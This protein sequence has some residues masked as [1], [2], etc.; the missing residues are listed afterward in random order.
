MTENKS[1]FHSAVNFCKSFGGDWISW[2]PNSSIAWFS[3]EEYLNHMNF[4][5]P[6]EDVF[7]H[8]ISSDKIKI[9]KLKLARSLWWESLDTTNSYSNI[10]NAKEKYKNF[11]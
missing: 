2:N 7:P 1:V 10:C 4:K 6:K 5:R 9:E 11:K 8:H 3:T